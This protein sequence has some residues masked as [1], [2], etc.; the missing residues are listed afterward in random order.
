MVDSAFH[1]PETEH[2]RAIRQIAAE[3]TMQGG[4]K[5]LAEF[6]LCYLYVTHIGDT[7]TIFPSDCSPRT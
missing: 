5:G 3:R 2:P 1:H 7:H 4:L 6:D